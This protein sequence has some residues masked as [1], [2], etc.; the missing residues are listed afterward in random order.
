MKNDIG[1]RGIDKGL[2]IWKNAKTSDYMFN[3]KEKDEE[4]G[5]YYY[6]A[7]YYSDED[8][9]FRAR[10][11]KFED[12]PFMSPYS[13]CGNNPVIYIDPDGRDRQLV[14]NHRR[15][16]ITVKANYYCNIN[17]QSAARKATE[18]FNNK[19]G[20]TYTDKDGK[21]WD[22]KFK[23][24]VIRV[25]NGKERKAANNDKQGNSFVLKGTV[26]HGDKVVAGLATNQ[27]YIDVGQKYYNDD[28]TSA[29]EIGHT[30]GMDHS[31]SGLMVPYLGHPKES[32]KLTQQNIND[33][34]ENGQGPPDKH[35]KPETKW[36]K[37][38]DFFG[39]LE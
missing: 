37:L 32:Q 22:V 39:L 19:A 12:Y 21:T 34:I 33:M 15:G 11:P 24:Q 16:T 10:D 28:Y 38:L 13:Y 20:L 35:I 29:H 30:L 1:H 27:K 31:E 5:L 25:D 26:K 7:R 3:A 23:L 9:V 2:F 8:I 14:Y 36:E 4:S 6:E 18:V 17:T